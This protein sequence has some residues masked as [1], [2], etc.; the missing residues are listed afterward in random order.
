MSRIDIKTAD[1]NELIQFIKD[2]NQ[3]LNR[4]QLANKQ[5]EQRIVQLEGKE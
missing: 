3:H 2:Q 4:L 1:R 5:C